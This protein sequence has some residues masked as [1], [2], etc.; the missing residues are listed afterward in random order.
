LGKG[1]VAEFVEDRVTLE[2]LAKMGVD[3]I[4]GY[5]FD[6]P[7]PDHPALKLPSR[8]TANPLRITQI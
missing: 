1:T 6:K 8:Q 2:L 7:C 5:V 3:L 4:Q